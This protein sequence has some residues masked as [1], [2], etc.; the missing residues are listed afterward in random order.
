[1][2]EG[3]QYRYSIAAPICSVQDL[4]PLLKAGA[5]EVYFGIMTDKWKQ[6]YGNAEFITRR[7]SEYAHISTFRQLSSIIQTVSDYNAN[8]TLV[9]NANYSEQQMP[10]VIEILSE[11]EER[12]GSAVM[13]ADLGVLLYLLEN[14]S[15]LNRYL[16]VMAGVFNHESVKF[17]HKLKVSR[18]VLPRELKLSEIYTLVKNSSS[19]IKFEVITMFQKCQFIDSFCKFIHAV[20]NDL[21]TTKKENSSSSNIPLCHGC[22][23]PFYSEGKPITPLFKD[24]INTPHCAACQLSGFLK[25]GINHFKIAGRGFPL[26]LI[27][28]AVSLTKKSMDLLYNPGEKIKEEYNNTFGYPC[29]RKYC[30]YSN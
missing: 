3:K 8:A 20:E 28:K 11:W 22:T 19:E 1:M 21:F 6:K 5:N 30:Y 15:K 26:E 29:K 23:I 16:S 7:Q 17:Y 4:E 2:P 12:G 18:I 14:N 9:L 27:I 10:F 13:V 25:N 24:D